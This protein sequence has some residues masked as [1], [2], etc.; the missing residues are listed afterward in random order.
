M[1]LVISIPPSGGIIQPSDKLLLVPNISRATLTLEGPLHIKKI[2]DERATVYKH[3]LEAERWVRNRIWCSPWNKKKP[4]KTSH[5]PLKFEPA[6]ASL[7][8]IGSIPK[9]I[10]DFRMNPFP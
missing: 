6:Q 2:P 8:V 5:W 4:S 10:Q 3:N 7:Q 9:T 1:K